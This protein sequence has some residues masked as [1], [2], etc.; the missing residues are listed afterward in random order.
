MYN[1]FFFNSYGFIITC[2]HYTTNILI[3]STCRSKKGLL[4]LVLYNTCDF[5]HINCFDFRCDL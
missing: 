2:M 4:V 3:V 5:V 1:N